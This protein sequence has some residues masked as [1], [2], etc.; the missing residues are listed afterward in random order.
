MPGTDDRS[1]NSS[2]ECDDTDG[3]NEDHQLWA[4][5][6]TTRQRQRFWRCGGRGRGRGRRGNA[7]RDRGG[8]SGDQGGELGSA[9]GAAAKE[10]AT[11]GDSANT[12]TALI[13]N[14]G[15]IVWMTQ[16]V[17]QVTGRHTIHNVMHI[18]LVP[19]RYARRNVDSEYQ[20]FDCSSD[21]RDPVLNE[22]EKWRDIEGRHVFAAWKN[23]ARDELL[24]YL[25]VLILIGIYR[26]KNKA[27]SDMLNQER[28][29]PVYSRSM[30]RNLFQ[31]IYSCPVL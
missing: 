14:S 2:N 9:D 30:A 29:R 1:D 20:H 13:S 31:Q 11:T 7:T 8:S 4:M 16:P 19:T 12:P 25:G 28:G 21:I 22:I 3:V 26:A 10:S 27:I 18:K 17:Q 24:R 23:V 15:N 6:Y 5:A